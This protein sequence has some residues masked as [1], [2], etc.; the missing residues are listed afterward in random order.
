MA[1]EI[2]C[3]SGF[4]MQSTYEF[5]ASSGGSVETGDSYQIGGE[6]S[7]R[8]NVSAAIAYAEFTA[9]FTSVGKY[10][11]G[12]NEYVWISFQVLIE[13]LPG[14]GAYYYLDEL[15]N[16][17]VSRFGGLRVDSSGQLS[18]LNYA[19][20]EDTGIYL[21]ENIW[22]T[23]AHKGRAGSGS[24]NRVYVYYTNSNSTLVGSYSHTATSNSA[25]GVA[26][27]KIG[28]WSSSTG[29]AVFDNFVYESSG[30]EADIDNPVDLLTSR[31]GVVLLHTDGNGDYNDAGWSGSYADLD[32]I[33]PS[34]S[35]YRQVSSSPAYCTHTMDPVPGSLLSY[36]CVKGFALIQPSSNTDTGVRFRSGS[37]NIDLANQTGGPHN[38]FRFW[39]DD[40]DTSLPWTESGI[41][42]FEVGAWRT[43]G[44]TTSY[45][46]SNHAEVLGELPKIFGV[47]V[48]FL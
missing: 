45:L 30:T 20:W 38:C 42:D 33:P 11:I 10:Q 26:R 14:T 40:P 1:H 31:Y 43:S 39:E 48:N 15:Y 36:E 8:F 5:Y 23:I 44:A 24:Q 18:I 27:V 22:Y 4:E 6:A 28:P 13:T 17:T 25:T 41:N 21:N 7:R 47:Q 12:S 3:F 2:E 37:T 34:T 35:D 29:N 32:E 19:T 9:S 46:Q 16:A